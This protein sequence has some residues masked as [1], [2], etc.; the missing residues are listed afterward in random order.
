MAQRRSS[1][2]R[3]PG[4][5]LNL[6]DEQILERMLAAKNGAKIKRLLDGDWKRQPDNPEYRYASHSEADLGLFNHLA[7]WTR[8]DRDRMLRLWASSGLFRAH[9]RDSYLRVTVDEAIASTPFGF[10]EEDDATPDD[11]EQAETDEGTPPDDGVTASTTVEP[12]SQTIQ[13]ARQRFAP[14]SLA[15]VLTIFRRWMYLE[16]SGPVLVVLAAI[17]ANLIKAIIPG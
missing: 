10:G 16:E 12:L 17:A 3:P 13:D 6:D 2:L 14:L 7:W 11:Q 15:D 9:K 4:E 5:P 1:E 8:R